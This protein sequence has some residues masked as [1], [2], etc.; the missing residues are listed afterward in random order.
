MKSVLHL[1]VTLALVVVSRFDNVAVDAFQIP[2]SST[3]KSLNSV[4]SS[5]SSITTTSL[6]VFGNKKSTSA[7]EQAKKEIYWQGD[8][9]CKDCGYIYNRVSDTAT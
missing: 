4:A 7:E 6:H 2:T 9:V 8:W 1:F 3:I 5:S